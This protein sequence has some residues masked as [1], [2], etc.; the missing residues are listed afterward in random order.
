MYTSMSMS[1]WAHRCFFFRSLET[2]TRASWSIWARWRSRTAWSP[3]R[4]AER[5]WRWMCTS[6]GCSLLK[7]PGQSSLYVWNV[8]IQFWSIRKCSTWS[9]QLVSGMLWSQKSQNWRNCG[10]WSRMVL[11]ENGRCIR[12]NRWWLL[13]LAYM[14]NLYAVKLLYRWKLWTAYIS[15][16]FWIIIHSD[17]CNVSQEL[18]TEAFLI[19]PSS[20]IY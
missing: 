15:R 1:E 11:A 6:S 4:V 8:T 5:A 10:H 13:T 19:E 20:L 7:S 16:Q 18:E 12:S 14:Y 2:R 17:T 9:H 3:L